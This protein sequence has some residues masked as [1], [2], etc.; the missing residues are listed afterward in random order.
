MDVLVC[1]D[2]RPFSLDI[3]LQTVTSNYSSQLN[4]HFDLQP[5]VMT[6]LNGHII[7]VFSLCLSVRFVR[8]VRWNLNK[9]KVV[10]GTNQGKCHEDEWGSEISAL[11]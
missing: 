7:F 8:E 4:T 1:S 2:R 5:R 3:N 6:A 9:G 10:S 11:L